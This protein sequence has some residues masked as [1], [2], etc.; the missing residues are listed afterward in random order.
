MDKN[1]LGPKLAISLRAPTHRRGGGAA[2]TTFLFFCNHHLLSHET[3]PGISARN[4]KLF[5]LFYTAQFSLRIV[6][7][8]V[9]SNS[10]RLFLPSL[11]TSGDVQLRDSNVKERGMAFQKPNCI[12]WLIKTAKF[13]EK[14]PRNASK[15]GDITLRR[16]DSMTYNYKTLQSIVLF[17]KVS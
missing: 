15:G 9:T 11:A 14:R 3:F 13:D 17:V 2:E 16:D 7:A 5:S 6:G 4:S 10:F 1:I 8:Y 12:R